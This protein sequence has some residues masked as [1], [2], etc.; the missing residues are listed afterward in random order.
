MKNIK[1]VR[2]KVPGTSLTKAREALLASRPEGPQGVDS[3]EAAIQWLE[4]DRQASGAA[5]AQKLDSRSANE[6]AIALAVLRDG[7]GVVRGTTPPQRAPPA[8]A[9]VEVACETDFVAKNPIFQ[10][11]ARDIVH[12]AASLPLLAERPQ[13]DVP[14]QADSGALHEISL[15]ELTQVPI[16]PS[17]PGAPPPKSA[18]T[19]QEA[20]VDAVARLG[21]NIK[22]RRAAVLFPAPFGAKRDQAAA[23]SGHV[24]VAAAYAHNAF[25][26]P[27]SEWTISEQASSELKQV[28]YTITVG[29]VGALI[30]ARL[31]QVGAPTPA[32]DA[33]SQQVRS[34]GRSLARQAAGMPTSS[35]FPPNSAARAGTVE[36][37]APAKEESEA[38]L[39]QPFLMLLGSA[40]PADAPLDS[41]Q[42]VQAVLRAWGEA[43]KVH[44]EA[45]GL[46]RWAVGETT[47]EDAPESANF[48]AEVRKAAGLP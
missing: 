2:E 26:E 22:V 8:A 3:V 15:E 17:H 16:L 48:A 38:L 13:G 21:E 43:N 44:A 46:R 5:K 14:A 33:L 42:S 39:E 6:G 11:L 29:K 35:L 36:A 12:T 34:L 19:I 25:P 27:E 4:K 20:I 47:A 32:Q 31:G 28:G 41:S 24:D 30:L 10:T 1:V 18:Q 40:V 9:I 37:S 45:T 23:S 7:W